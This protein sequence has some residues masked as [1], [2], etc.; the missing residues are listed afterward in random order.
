MERAVERRF[1]VVSVVV[2]MELNLEESI[3]SVEAAGLG[4]AWARRTSIWGLGQF[5][6]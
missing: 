3:K 2:M 1:T 6:G 4:K 5:V